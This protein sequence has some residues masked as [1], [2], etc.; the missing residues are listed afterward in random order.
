MGFNLTTKVGWENLKYQWRWGIDW[1]LIFMDTF[2]IFYCRLF[3]HREYETDE[4]KACKRGH[5]IAL[6][7]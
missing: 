5:W 3:G 1:K 4:G 7:E 2:S 6:K